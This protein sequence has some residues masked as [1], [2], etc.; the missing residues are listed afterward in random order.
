VGVV[1]KE[2][3]PEVDAIFTG[4]VD[5]VYVRE[6]L[7]EMPADYDPRDRGWY[8]QAME[9]KGEIVISDPYVSASTGEMVVSVSQTNADGS[10]VTALDIS[11]TSSRANVCSHSRS[12]C[13]I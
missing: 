4:N 12:N 1:D 10:G 8:K 6:P 9:R 11:L 5:G 13:A 7:V 2:I 3:H